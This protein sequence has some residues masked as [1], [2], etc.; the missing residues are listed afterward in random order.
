M[1]LAAALIAADVSR[2]RRLR[3]IGQ[4]DPRRPTTLRGDG[5]TLE[6]L[7]RAPGDDVAVVAGTA[8]HEPGEVRVSFLVVERRG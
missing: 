5:Q 6:E 1:R 2:A 7:W 3:R 8:N 4:T